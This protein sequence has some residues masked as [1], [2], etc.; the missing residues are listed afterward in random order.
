MSQRHQGSVCSPKHDSSCYL[1]RGKTLVISRSRLCD[2]GSRCDLARSEGSRDRGEI[3]GPRDLEPLSWAIRL[4]IADFGL[5]RERKPD[6]DTPPRISLGITSLPRS[7]LNNLAISYRP[8]RTGV[9]LASF[10]RE[11]AKPEDHLAQAVGCAG[12]CGIA[13]HHV[14]TGISRAGMRSGFVAGRGGR[15]EDEMARSL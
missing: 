13:D 1:V 4:S 3:R 6:D 12:R 11:A 9:Y 5:A 10:F 7:F 15:R 2:A 8:R 14:A